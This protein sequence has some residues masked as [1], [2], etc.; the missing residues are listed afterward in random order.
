M[1]RRLFTSTALVL[2]LSAT[3]SFAQTKWDLPAAYPATNFHTENL[4]QFAKDVD[5]ASGG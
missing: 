3:G 2:A 5:T 4:T 1:K